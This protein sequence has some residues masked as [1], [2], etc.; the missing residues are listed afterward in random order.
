ML[1]KQNLSIIKARRILT[2]LHV[3]PKSVG[4][5]WWQG[6]RETSVHERTEC[7]SETV[8][9]QVENQT[10]FQKSHSIAK[11]HGLL[12]MVWGTGVWVITGLASYLAIENGTLDVFQVTKWID[13][14]VG[15]SWAESLD[16]C[17]S[18][19]VLACAANQTISPLR[20]AFVVATMPYIKKLL[21]RR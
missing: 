6:S 11:E 15:T 18:N 12:F 1:T 17:N 2:T 9:L 8:A 20:L 4:S 7:Y 14:C 3:Q 19:V 10:V 16:T 5:F 21:F 13:V